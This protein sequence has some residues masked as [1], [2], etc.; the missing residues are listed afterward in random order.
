MQGVK[1]S[2][3]S[4]E[5]KEKI[6]E[7]H[8]PVNVMTTQLALQSFPAHFYVVF[9]KHYSFLADLYPSPPRLLNSV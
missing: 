8:P 3:G 5:G 2:L 7:A 6:R 4:M 1:S 9:H